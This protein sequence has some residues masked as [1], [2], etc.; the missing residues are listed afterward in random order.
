MAEC[1]L[2]S[3]PADLPVPVDDG[4]ADHLVGAT[5]PDGVRLRA[6][7]GSLVRW[8]T[9]LCST[10]VWVDKPSTRASRACSSEWWSRK[11]QDSG[12]QPRAPTKLCG[13][14]G[15]RRCRRWRIGGETLLRRLT[16]LVDD[17]VVTRV[18]YP[19]FPPDRHAAEVVE[20]LG[21]REK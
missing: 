6:T 5:L 18:W 16:L 21:I 10:V 12:V 8:T 7:A 11:P 19:V 9:S 13:S 14:P 3:L 17:G 20:T 2:L 15:R 4:A 1:D